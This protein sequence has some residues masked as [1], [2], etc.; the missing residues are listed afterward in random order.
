MIWETQS[1][2]LVIIVSGVESANSTAVESRK[3]KSMVSCN[4]PNALDGAHVR[5][6]MSFNYRSWGISCEA[7]SWT[8]RKGGLSSL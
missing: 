8:T 3:S 2:L 6:V 4:A 7:K 1:L 5:G